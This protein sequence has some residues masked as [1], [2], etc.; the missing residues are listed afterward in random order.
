MTGPDPGLIGTVSKANGIPLIGLAVVIFLIGLF[1]R[2]HFGSRRNQSGD[3]GT[4]AKFQYWFY[5]WVMGIVVC[6]AFVVLGIVILV[7][8]R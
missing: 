7:T 6:V 3:S 4:V 8:G 2:H 5:G 1:N